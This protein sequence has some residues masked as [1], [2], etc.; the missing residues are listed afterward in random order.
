MRKVKKERRRNRILRYDISLCVSVPSVL[1]V[2]KN[3]F[4]DN[5]YQVRKCAGLGDG[6]GGTESSATVILSV[7][8]SP[9]CSLC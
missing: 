8:L 7:S 4:C 1:S 6:D 9:L 5:L 3:L 2:L